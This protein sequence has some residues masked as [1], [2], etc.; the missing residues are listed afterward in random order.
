M[1]GYPQGGGGSG[2]KVRPLIQES[3]ILPKGYDEQEADNDGIE[4]ERGPQEP[5][6]K[7]EWAEIELIERVFHRLFELILW[8]RVS[9]MA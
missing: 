4:Y 1:S 3:E 6:S 8:K 9:I 5:F 7:R 2:Y